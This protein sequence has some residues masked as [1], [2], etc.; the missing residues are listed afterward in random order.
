MPQS[1]EFKV[2]T[3]NFTAVGKSQSSKPWKVND[4]MKVA[5]LSWLPGCPFFS[6][7]HDNILTGEI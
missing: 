3:Q 5:T 7:E 6:Y 1:S 4:P 2:T